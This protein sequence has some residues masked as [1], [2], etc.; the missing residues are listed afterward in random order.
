M[1]YEIFD[2]EG[3]LRIPDAEMW[4]RVK[5]QIKKAVTVTEVF[6]P[7][8]H[9]LIDP[10]HPVRGLPGIK[11]RFRRPRGEYGM[12]I[13]S[14]TLGCNDKLVLSGKLVEGELLDLSCPVCMV[15][16]PILSDCDCTNKGVVNLLYLTK[17]NNPYDA[18]GVCNVVGC[19]NSSLIR[20]GDVVR[21]A[22]LGRW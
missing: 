7:R 6:C 20:S 17:D 3:K 11:L 10:E 4:D 12:L 8:G 21:A 9:D 18:I 16:L 19:P 14:P 15:S 5:D 2:R 1:P 13:L 22:R